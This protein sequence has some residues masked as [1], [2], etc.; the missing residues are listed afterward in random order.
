MAE[1]PAD[2]PYRL[3]ESPSL[4]A[5]LVQL[6]RTSRAASAATARFQQPAR[7]RQAAPSTSQ[8]LTSAITS[9]CSLFL[10]FHRLFARGRVRTRHGQPVRPSARELE[11]APAKAYTQLLKRA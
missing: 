1:L 10:D 7:P 5:S 3:T 11:I 9:P 2:S 6:W 8:G 4:T